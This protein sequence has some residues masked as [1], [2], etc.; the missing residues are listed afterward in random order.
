[1]ASTIGTL[2]GLRFRVN[3]SRTIRQR[4]LYDYTGLVP[5][6]HVIIN[7]EIINCVW[8]PNNVFYVTFVV[9]AFHVIPA[10][11]AWMP[12]LGYLGFGANEQSWISGYWQ[13]D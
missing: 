1:M 11:W 5:E 13:L 10:I 9:Q 7:F 12:R 6:T 2:R 4:W 3:M 8:T